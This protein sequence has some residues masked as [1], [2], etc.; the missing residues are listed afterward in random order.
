MA[1]S[2]IAP[3]LTAAVAGLRLQVTVTVFALGSIVSL[4]EQ[5]LFRLSFS[6]CIEKD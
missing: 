2:V 3:V 1:E 5:F 4:T 6:H